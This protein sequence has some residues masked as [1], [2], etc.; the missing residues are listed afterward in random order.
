MR[1]PKEDPPHRTGSRYRS[2]RETY[3][4][5]RWRQGDKGKG[6]EIRTLEDPRTI[7]AVG[8]EADVG[9]IGEDGDG[10]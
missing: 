5:G 9:P 1:M 3:R 2:R 4:R 8:I 10:W 7:P 6:R